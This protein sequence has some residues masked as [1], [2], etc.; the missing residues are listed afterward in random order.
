MKEDGI[1]SFRGDGGQT[2]HNE[3]EGEEGC[4]ELEQLFAEEV[5]NDEN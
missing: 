5:V 2:K 1:V 3:V 4:H